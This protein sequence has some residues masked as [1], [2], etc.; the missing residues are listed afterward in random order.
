MRR[1]A[2][3]FLVLAAPALAQPPF[4]EPPEHFY[5]AKGSRVG[6][7]WACDRTEL[8]EGETLTAVLTVRNAINP[9][10]IVRPD[11]RK[12]PPFNDA[13]QIDDV[14]GPPAKPKDAEVKFVYRLKPR[15]RAVTK[16]PSLDFY[17]ANPGLKDK[18]KEQ[19]MKTVARWVP[20]TVTAVAP[21]PRQVIPLEGDADLFRHAEGGEFVMLGREPFAPSAGLWWLLF[22]GVPALAL[23][24]FLAWRRVYPDAAR[25]SR[26]RRGRAARRATDAIRRAART[27]DPAGTVA[28][29]VLGYLRARHPLPVGAETPGAIGDALRDAGHPDDGVVRFFRRCDEARF[30]EGSD[31]LLSL[32]KE[33]AA[34]IARLE[35]TA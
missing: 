13:F 4:W 21:K 34:L 9:N 14:P 15:N 23:L 22:V 28:A 19:F 24:W 20:I 1:I 11:L 27:P 6:A 7:S 32:A 30:S 17:F 2:L 12:L 10:E 8:P 35:A 26:I 33:A 3:S 29:A 25:L 16:V 5:K 18:G 31:N